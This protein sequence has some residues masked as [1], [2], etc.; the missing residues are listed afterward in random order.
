M[1]DKSKR[2]FTLMIAFKRAMNERFRRSDESDLHSMLRMAA[3][4]FIGSQKDPTMKDIASHLMVRPSS[5][6]PLVRSMESKGFV[7]R[8][9]DP[10]DRRTVRIRLTEKG[11][12]R[13][14]EKRRMMEKH[15][16]EVIG[17]LTEKEKTTFITLLEKITKI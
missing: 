9:A 5:V 1:P 4:F 15:L 6:T 8:K 7:V 16:G 10:N 3:M 12:K 14:A 11:R 2:I 13:L 17:P